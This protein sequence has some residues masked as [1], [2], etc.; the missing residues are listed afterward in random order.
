MSNPLIS[1]CIPAYNAEEFLSEALESIA[2]QTY[3]NWEIV[4]TEDGSKDNTEKI[5]SSFASRVEQ[6]VTYLRHSVNKGLSASRNTCIKNCR[7]DYLALIDSDDYWE[8]SHLESL[9][10]KM[11]ETNPAVVH[12]ASQEF[13]TDGKKLNIRQ[14][15]EYALKNIEKEL[16]LFRYT[17][18]PSSTLIKKSALEKSGYFDEQRRVIEDLDL[19]LRILDSGGRIV[20]TGEVTC[21]YRIHKNSLTADS[22]RLI[23]STATL[24]RKHINCKAVPLEQKKRKIEKN[25]YSAGKMY[26]RNNPKASRECFWDA[27]QFRK[28]KLHYLLLIAMSFLYQGT[29]FKRKEE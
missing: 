23:R 5:L 6:P 29:F 18:Q 11:L 7:G 1:I 22:A 12:S 19:W 25:F 4:L 20:F 9:V 14:P 2:K 27:W 3:S 13:T 15:S 21:N 10:N 17:I 28:T 24:M 8:P 16:F 26:F